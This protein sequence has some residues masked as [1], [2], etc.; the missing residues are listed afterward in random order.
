M[1]CRGDFQTAPRMEA[2][3]FHC[4][5]SR[6]C[7]TRDA[8]RRNIEIKLRKAN[9]DKRRRPR[10]TPWQQRAR[11]FSSAN[12]AASLR[13]GNWSLM[14]P[15][16]GWQWVMASY[17]GR[18]PKL[19]SATPLALGEMRPE[20]SRRLVSTNTRHYCSARF[21]CTAAKLFLNFTNCGAEFLRH[22]PLEGARGVLL[23]VRSQT[24]A[25]DFESHRRP[26]EHPLM[27]FDAQ[28]R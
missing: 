20:T 25:A 17:P 8:K 1:F 24:K 27:K 23:G 11:K 12:G 19:S 9:S 3:T 2:N 26:K 10:A 21:F 14:P 22:S 13:R 4:E 6:V 15:L 7:A 16:Q 28:N 5:D 18:C